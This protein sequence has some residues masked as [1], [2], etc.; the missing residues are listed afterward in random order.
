MKLPRLWDWIIYAAAL[1]GVIYL[2]SPQNLPV[3]ID[4]IALAALAG[5]VGY[6]LDLS[7]YPYGRPDMLV[8]LEDPSEWGV[9]EAIVFAAAMGRRAIIIGAVIVAVALGA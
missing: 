4:K 9:G 2:L 5:L 8:A 6:R 7:L 1:T 3:M